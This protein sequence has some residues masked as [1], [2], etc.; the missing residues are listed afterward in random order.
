MTADV[1]VASFNINHGCSFYEKENIAAQAALIRSLQAD[2]VFFQEVDRFTQRCGGVD[3]PAMLSELS[4]LRFWAYGK[5]MDYQGGEYGE[6]VVSR[7]PFEGFEV[8]PLPH[9]PTHEPRCA[10][11]VRI[12][13]PAVG[14][15]PHPLQSQQANAAPVQT[16]PVV[17]VGTHL[18]HEDDGTD[19]CAQALYLRQWL[20]DGGG[21][22]CVLA[23]DL[24]DVPESR[25]L[26]TFTT[27]CASS[28]SSLSSSSMSASSFSAWED[29]TRALGCTWPAL[30]PSMKIDYVLTAPSASHTWTCLDAL[31]PA[32]LCSDHRAVCV[33]LR[34]QRK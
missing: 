21:L 5:A 31:C 12:S 17:F 16:I 18:D 13:L 10:L 14:D 29:A 22:P 11:V 26:Q 20:N 8:V 28:S 3:Q 33:H 27:A 25:V 23:G 24:N 32:D 9:H 19:R 6:A 4:G 30:E 1:K 2:V 34:L 15:G 7:Y